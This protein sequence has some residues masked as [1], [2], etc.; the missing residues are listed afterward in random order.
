MDLDE[1]NLV[2]SS[3]EESLTTISDSEI[4]IT[5]DSSIQ[6]VRPLIPPLDPSPIVPPAI[7][8]L[9]KITPITLYLSV[10]L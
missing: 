3:L 6:P 7:A 8:P 9:S 2:S 10:H 5:V 1:E 4:L